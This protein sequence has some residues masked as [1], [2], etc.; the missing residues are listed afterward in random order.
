MMP[1]VVSSIKRAV[2][3]RQQP[4]KPGHAVVQ[5]LALE[6]G[7]VH[8]LVHRREHGHEREPKSEPSEEPKHRAWS[9]E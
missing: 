9:L 7:A 1:A 8:G 3:K 4:C 2:V 5:T 6:G